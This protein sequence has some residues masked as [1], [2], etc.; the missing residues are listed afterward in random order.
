MQ[1][2]IKNTFYWIRTIIT[3]ATV[4]TLF[5]YPH[6]LGIAESPLAKKMRLELMVDFNGNP[7]GEGIK[8][9]ASL[10]CKFWLSQQKVIQLQTSIAERSKNSSFEIIEKNTIFLEEY[11]GKRKALNTEMKEKSELKIDGKDWINSPSLLIAKK[12]LELDKEK[13]SIDKTMDYFRR[14]IEESNDKLFILNQ[15]ESIVRDKH[16]NCFK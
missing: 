14:A 2:T 11:D 5:F 16:A 15:L 12:I 4:F 10:D 7:E 13:S 9:A 8:L 6:L 1:I 3:C